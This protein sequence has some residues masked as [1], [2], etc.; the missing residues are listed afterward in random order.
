MEPITIT[1]LLV[2]PTLFLAFI[3]LGVVT[4]NSIDNITKKQVEIYD[5]KTSSAIA[6]LLNKNYRVDPDNIPWLR[7]AMK[8]IVSEYEINGKNGHKIKYKCHISASEMDFDKIIPQLSEYL[9]RNNIYHKFA[10]GYKLA[11]KSVGNQYGKIA[12]IYCKSYEDF[13]QVYLGAISLAKK[14]YTGISYSNFVRGKHNMKYEVEIPGTNSILYY[15][16]ERVDGNYCGPYRDPYHY[17]HRLN[18]LMNNLG[19]GPLDNKFELKNV[20]NKEIF[21][22]YHKAG[23]DMV[24]NTRNFRELFSRFNNESMIFTYAFA[25]EDRFRNDLL[26][27][28]KY[29]IEKNNYGDSKD[30]KKNILE[31]SSGFTRAL[32]IRNKVIE[33]CK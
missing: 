32:G 22:D 9:I 1:L 30:D 25:Y 31:K 3:S 24:S 5:G 27:Q 2:L 11:R 28:M 10:P 12:T 19:R 26:D 33:L 29:L 16:V 7:P 6:Y 13:Q 17:E 18:F 23:I 8:K 20:I 4:T 21:K 14:G 15:T